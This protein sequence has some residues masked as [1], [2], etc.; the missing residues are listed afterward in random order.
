MICCP[1][2]YA[3]GRIANLR[4]GAYEFR[5][6]VEPVDSS[7]RCCMVQPLG[8]D[9]LSKCRHA[10]ESHTRFGGEPF[11]ATGE[12]CDQ[13]ARSR[14]YRPARRALVLSIPGNGVAVPLGRRRRRTGRPWRS[15][16]ARRTKRCPADSRRFTGIALGN[17]RVTR[18]YELPPLI[19]TRS[20]LASVQ[21]PGIV[22]RLVRQLVSTVTSNR[23]NCQERIRTQRY[24]DGSAVALLVE[25]QLAIEIC[26]VISWATN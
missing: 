23:C 7:L 24:F 10:H 21:V 15:E 16:G 4:C 11:G 3:V 6:T 14:R 8:V 19:R 12:R 13:A 20:F 25:I 2:P 9:K 17:E 18:G 1:D 22:P 5:T 26:D